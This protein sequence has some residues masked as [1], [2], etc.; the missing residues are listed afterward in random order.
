M[1]AFLASSVTKA[2]LVVAI[3]C[4]PT[5]RA[6][7]QDLPESKPL[8]DVKAMAAKPT[9]KTPD[10]HPDLNGR[11][12]P[13]RLTR[14]VR[15]SYGKVVGNEHQLIFGIPITGDAETDAAVTEKLNDVKHQT[16]KKREENA[17]QY[18]PEFV[19]KVKMMAIDVNHYDPTTYSCLPPGVPRMGAPSMITEIPGAMLFLYGARPYSTFRVIPVDKP[20]RKVDDDFDPNPMGDSV[21]HWD[22]NTFVV[23]TTGFD[24]TTWFGAAGYFHSDAMHV[25]EKFTRKGETLEYSVTVEDPKV[26]TKPFDLNPNPQIFKIDTSND[27]LYNQ[28]LPCDI[29]GNH[30][31]RQHADHEHNIVN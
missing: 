6:G 23:D 12:I 2:A 30:D 16:A 7:A 28:D 4:I 3:V 24:D 11:W 8:D 27:V 29:E 25:V 31:F 18:K 20:H 14:G 26:L 15:G 19:D 21:G 10:G 1:K 22:G 5:S 9:P 13:P 17:P